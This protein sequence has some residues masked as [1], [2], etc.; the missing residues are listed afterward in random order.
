MVSS[1]SLSDSELEAL[2]YAAR[3]LV[4]WTL[5]H[6]NLDVVGTR[7]TIQLKFDRDGIKRALIVGSK[8]DAHWGFENA[9]E[10]TLVKVARDAFGLRF[11]FDGGIECG[12]KA[13][14][15]LN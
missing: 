10:R 9:S 8:S 14:R 12:I 15:L 2:E 11:G 6:I 1:D 7:P 3:P 5:E 13:G 4:G